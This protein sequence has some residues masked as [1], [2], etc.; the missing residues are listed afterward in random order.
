[1][2]ALDVNIDSRVGRQVMHASEHEIVRKQAGI[3]ASGCLMCSPYTIV[4]P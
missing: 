1:M 3:S 2:D 4:G